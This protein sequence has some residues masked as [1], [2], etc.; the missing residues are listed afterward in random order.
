[1]LVCAHV[2]GV[3]PQLMGALCAAL[4]SRLAWLPSLALLGVSTGTPALHAL[5]PQHAYR[6]LTMQRIW[7]PP[8]ASYLNTLIQSL[9]FSTAFPGA[10]SFFYP[11]FVCLC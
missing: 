6:R 10:F 7:L 1:M 9:L 4:A 2:E 11:C 3:E 5:L 8:A